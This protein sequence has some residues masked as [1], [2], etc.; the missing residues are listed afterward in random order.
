MAMK[1][2]PP[3]KADVTAL[4]RNLFLQTEQE[5]IREITR[6]R[7][8]GHV[9]YAEVAALE[10][11]QKILQNMVDTSWSYVP[12]MI[13]KIFYHSDKDAA[14]YTN[15]RTITGTRSV[16]QIAIM[17]Q[18]ANNLQGE[19][20]EMAGTAK[21]SV[22]NVFTIAR[23]E[24][25]PYRKLA[26]E[27]IL[28]QEAAGKPW[29]KSSQDLVKE[30]ETNGITGFTDKAG[31]K[32]SMQAYGNMAVRTT[33]RQAEVA[34]LLSSDEY[35]LWQI[36][37]VGTTC[38]VCAPLEGRVYSKSGTNPDYPPLT[39]AFGKV[40]PAG[41]DDLS[42]TY[43]NIHPNCLHALV[44]YTTIG[45]SAE[46]IQKDKDFSSIEKNPLNRDPRTK[47]QIAAYREKE[48]NRQKLLRDMKQHKEYRAILGNDIP[49]DFAKFRELKYNNAEKWDK[50]HILYQDDK[51]KKKIRSPEVNKTIEEGKQGKHIL[52]HKN[53]KDGRSYLKVSV[54]EAQ[55]LVD[56]YAGT[57]QIKR[58]SKGHWT[59]KEFVSADHI[60]GVVVDANMG[61]T[62][63][64]SRFSIHYSKN[65]VHIVPRKE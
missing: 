6:K 49:K 47:K 45:K 48:R 5:L 27:Q 8:A 36:T 39:V 51:L 35:D 37:K 26:L 56:Q 32:W 52:G 25:D 4:L 18:L 12:V 31:R 54:E 58:D 44:K 42:N 28:R 3:K 57:G 50:I 46:R 41:A 43:L 24:N 40:D 17:E 33:A 34:A 65:G 63:E 7:A 9:E 10:R 59:N 1:I 20:M 19:L 53:Y 22:E 38:P 15:A 60:I 55:R 21:R 14:G 13:E 2:R 64:T 11:V 62:I 61:E 16:T 23:L 29:I 30:M